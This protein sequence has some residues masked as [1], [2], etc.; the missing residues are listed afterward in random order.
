MQAVILAAGLSSR[1]K[2]NKLQLPIQGIPILQRIVMTLQQ[3]CDLVIVVTGRY[4]HDV[5]ELLDGMKGVQL[6]HNE[7]YELGM[8]T[9]VQKGVSVVQGDFFLVPGDVPIFSVD[10]LD[11]LASAHGM[12]RVPVF[13]GRRGHPIF[14]E[15]SLVTSLLK[16]PPTSNLR[17]FRDRYDVVYVEVPDPGVAMDVDTLEDYEQLLARIDKGKVL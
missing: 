3:K 9:S 10:T 7:A 15:G 12:F 13:E 5:L 8:F 6:V 11:R 1:A 17:K 4:Q 14:M 16:E 2:Q